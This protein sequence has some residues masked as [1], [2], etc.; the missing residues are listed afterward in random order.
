MKS[1]AIV[2]AVLLTGCAGQSQK[3][4]T[5]LLKDVHRAERKVNSG[6]VDIAIGKA[7]VLKGTAKKAEGEIERQTAVDQLLNAIN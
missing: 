7:I 4:E 6:M 1:V 5:S 3:V 2:L